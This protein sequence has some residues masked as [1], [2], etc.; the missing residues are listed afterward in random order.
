MCECRS[1][2]RGEGKKGARDF[3][4]PA[5]ERCDHLDFLGEIGCARQGGEALAQAGLEGVAVA[6]KARG[7]AGGGRVDVA[8]MLSIGQR[9]VTG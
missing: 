7:R 8:T 3:S 6:G 5:G 9:R 1:P 4:R 2:R